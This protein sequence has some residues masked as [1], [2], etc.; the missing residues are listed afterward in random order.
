MTDLPHDVDDDDRWLAAEHALGVLD[1]QQRH[2]A[3]ARYDADPAFRAEVD[4][5]FATLSP[6]LAA[7]PAEASPSDLWPAIQDRITRE[8]GVLAF[9]P[10][11]GGGGDDWARN[12]RAAA[13]PRR[14]VRFW[15][16]VSAT[17]GALAA[18]ALVVA[19][20][21]IIQPSEV[22]PPAV[23]TP[24]SLP[25]TMAAALTVSD[26]PT[27]FAVLVDPARSR[28]VVVPL[29][30]DWDQARARELWLIPAGSSPVSVGLLEHGAP[31]PLALDPAL[32]AQAAGGTFAVSDEPPG[33][34]PQPTPTGD[35]VASGALKVV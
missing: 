6:M 22:A 11:E 19:V 16:G 26:A 13:N 29:G 12:D 14:E 34:S 33:G 32:L 27:Q 31:T 28:V 4:D 25:P 3:E 30:S 17:A 2:A 10:R 15:R 21:P 5:W 35:V 9:R 20:M 18:A 8:S 23:V 24:T 7:L 1:G